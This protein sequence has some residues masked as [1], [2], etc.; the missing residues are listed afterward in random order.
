M[1]RILFP[2]DRDGE[3]MSDSEKASGAPPLANPEEMSE[4]VGGHR[5]LLSEGNSSVEHK[6]DSQDNIHIKDMDAVAA[7]PALSDDD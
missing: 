2:T 7:D 3:L 5:I 1:T 4:L 6:Q